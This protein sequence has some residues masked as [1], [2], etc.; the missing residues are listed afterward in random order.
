MKIDTFGV[1]M[2][3]NEWETKCELNLAETCV[4]SLTIK[5]LL[6][7]TGR[8][9]ADLSAL[10]HLK[11]TYGEIKGSDR[12][13]AAVASL[14]SKQNDTNILIT[15]GTIG[16]NMLVHKTLIERGDRVIS[17]VP[18]YQ[19]HY[20][21]LYHN[22]QR[23]PPGQNRHNGRHTR[24]MAAVRQRPEPANQNRCS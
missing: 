8:N 3:M 22:I 9:E 15:H 7:I 20:H 14:Y 4:E 17:I 12:L 6:E 5:Q 21:H 18:T 10:L 24:A 11:M 1:E 13:R 2:W 23:H 19:Q 16:A